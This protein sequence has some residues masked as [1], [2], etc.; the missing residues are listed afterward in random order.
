MASAA[1]FGAAAFVFLGCERETA[2]QAPPQPTVQGKTITFPTN[3]PQ[4]A[5]L[6][7]APAEPQRWTVAHFT[8]RLYWD[9]DATARVFTP[10]AGHVTKLFPQLGDAIVAGAPLAEIDSPD[11]GQAL[12]DARAAQGNLRLAER[13]LTRTR[14]LLAHGATAQKDVENAEAAATSAA[15]E[16]DR[17]AARLALYGGNTEATNEL[18]ILRSPLAG[19]LVEKNV[20]PGQEVRAD[21]MLA[22]ATQLYAPLFVVSDPSRLWLQVDAAE[23]DLTS[24]KTGQRLRIHSR[25][26]PGQVFEGTVDNIGDELDPS[27]RTVKVRGV[28]NN[29]GHQLKA[30]MYVAVDVLGE[31][32]PAAGAALEIPAKAVFMRDNQYYLF[33]EKSPVEFERLPVT[34]GPEQDARVPIL[35]GLEANQKVVTDG[36][37][38]LEALIE[39]GENT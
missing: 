21:Q 13:T 33:V 19:V 17:A 15:A 24:L 10:V 22:N 18:F 36:C 7:V 23:S 5:S 16:R 30:E 29:P 3:S 35:K 11:F 39:S 9:D 31:A 37:L 14:E 38:L 8:G 2:V 6:S 32:A 1:A 20:N 12:A 27:T 28:V 26:F 4:I 25:A 34:I